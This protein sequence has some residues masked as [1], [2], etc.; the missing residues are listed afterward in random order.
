MVYVRPDAVGAM[1][2]LVYTSTV[3]A[4]VPI[5]PVP[6]LPSAKVVFLVEPLLVNVPEP[7]A[8]PR[9]VLALRTVNVPVVAPS[10]MALLAWNAVTVV[11]V[12]LNRLRVAAL[13]D[14]VAAFRAIPPDPARMVV[15]LAPLVEPMVT[16]WTAPVLVAILTVEA[17]AAAPTV[18]I[19]T[20]LAAAWL[21]TVIM[22][23]AAVCS[24]IAEAPVTFTA[25]PLVLPMVVVP[26]PV[27][28]ILVLPVTVVMPVRPMLVPL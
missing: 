14:M 27:V 6:R 3:A 17:N 1:V 19:F 13:V 23:E 2:K 10:D 4:A 7:A 26:A 22:P 24:E 25:P 21:P 15:A 9:V 11:A 16:V 20:V 5:A 8:L 12:A 28:L 18:P